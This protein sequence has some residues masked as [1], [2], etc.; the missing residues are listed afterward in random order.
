MNENVSP[1]VSVIMG[2]YNNE[3]TIGRCIDSVESQTFTDWEF[4]ICD[5]HSED[6]TYEI[7]ERRA[8]ADPR[9]KLLR[10]KRNM[11]LAYCLNRCLKAASGRYIARMDDDDECF[12]DRFEKQ[13]A[14][15]DKYPGFDVVGSSFV[16]ISE[17][18][19]MGV[20]VFP[21]F[22]DESLLLKN[23][24]FCHPSVMMRS[25]A[26]A[27]LGG[28]RSVKETMRAEDLDL[29]FRFFEK[30]LKGYN[31]QEPLIKRTIELSDYKKRTLRSGIMTAKV[32]LEGYRRIGIPV[33]KRI[34]ALKPVVSAVMPDR[35][36][37]RYHLS[38]L[39]KP[40]GSSHRL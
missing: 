5:D 16:M 36:L 1:A 37:Y 39:V 21:D 17:G 2:T 22:P 33:Y 15:L 9:I 29:W 30:G 28:Y 13:T 14:F 32:Y 25:E 20:C 4:I 10:N 23:P 24:P 19:D 6:A 18:R 7:L 11:R 38:K 12:P 35:I 34:F 3:K 31:M 26:Y 40:R 8:A 27:K